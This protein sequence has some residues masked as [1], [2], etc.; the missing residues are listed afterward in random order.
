MKKIKKMKNKKIKTQIKKDDKLTIFEIRCSAN[1]SP[2]GLFTNFTNYLL[3][4]QV[5]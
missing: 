1:K 3:V 5:K 2:Q 4:F